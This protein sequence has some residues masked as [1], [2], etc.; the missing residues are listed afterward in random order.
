MARLFVMMMV[1]S[2]PLGSALRIPPAPA[3]SKGSI[4]TS[5]P[6]GWP[7]ALPSP[8]A[9]ALL[10]ALLVTSSPAAPALAALPHTLKVPEAMQVEV[11]APPE[12]SRDDPA[13][14]ALEEVGRLV[15]SEKERTKVLE[16][17]RGLPGAA[18]DAA[19]E[20]AVQ[21]PIGAEVAQNVAGIR[22]KVDEQVSVVADDPTVKQVGEAFAAAKEVYDAPLTQSAIAGGQK[23]I[24]AAGGLVAQAL[25]AVAGAGAQLAGGAIVK[26]AELAG[27]GAVAAAPVI[28]EKASWLAQEAQETAVS[29]FNALQDDVIKAAP[30]AAEAQ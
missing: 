7:A 12:A 1:A 17:A 5:Q 21:T 9:S 11:S 8:L 20:M 24:G 3:V 2:P 15:V 22:E 4:S 6:S 29:T 13:A 10:A 28:A 27:E 30:P 26:G 16:K 23:V 25:G 19:L 18:A 14:A